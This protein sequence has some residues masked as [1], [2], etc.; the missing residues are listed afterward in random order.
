MERARQ[1]LILPTTLLAV[2]LGAAGAGVGT[3]S[4]TCLRWAPVPV[5]N[6]PQDLTVTDSAADG[7]S[8]TLLRPGIYHVEM[9]LQ[10]VAAS[11][12][13]AGF[14]LNAALPVA[15]NPV[16]G[17]NGVIAALGPNTR[18]AADTGPTTL[19]RTIHVRDSGQGAVLRTLASDGANATPIPALT[20]ATCWLSITRAVD[21][22]E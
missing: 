16:M 5:P 19:A 10:Q 3:A 2:G 21:Q 4:V 14:S 17:A 18:P 22:G 12:I 15:A 8:F 9:V 7:M 11:T 6:R 1:A 13:F 20:I